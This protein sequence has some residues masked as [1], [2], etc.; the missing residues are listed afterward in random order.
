MP[1]K[2]EQSKVQPFNHY[3]NIL[4]HFLWC[5][6]RGLSQQELV[7]ACLFDG[8]PDEQTAISFL[9]IMVRGNLLHP[10]RQQNGQ[11]CYFLTAFWSED[12]LS[13][14]M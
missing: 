2:L 8:C 14:A 6:E 5:G 11:T 13:K 10:I 7:Q 4:N 1:C 9:E 3:E 12:R